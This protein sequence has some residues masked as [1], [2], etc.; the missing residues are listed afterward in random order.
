MS[1]F[2]IRQPQH[3]DWEILLV[4]NNLASPIKAKERN[5]LQVDGLIKVKVLQ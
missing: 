3:N 4:E 1:I 5:K 2:S